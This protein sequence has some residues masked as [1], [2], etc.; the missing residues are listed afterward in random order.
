MDLKH[1]KDELS[2][3]E[4]KVI[5]KEESRIKQHLNNSKQ[6]PR[7]YNSKRPEILYE[8]LYYDIPHVAN[9]SFVWLA[10]GVNKDKS[11][12]IL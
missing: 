12:L 1:K 3:K 9:R 11:S 10:K 4:Y 5:T 2:F 6:E 8:E 7:G